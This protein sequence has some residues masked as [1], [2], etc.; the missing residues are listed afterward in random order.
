MMRSKGK[1]T[2]ALCSLIA[3]SNNDFEGTAN[4]FVPPT[5]TIA[6]VKLLLMPSFLNVKGSEFGDEGNGAVDAIDSRRM[7]LGRAAGGLTAAML[8]L[9]TTPS[10]AIA[11]PA[12]PKVSANGS[13]K[14]VVKQLKSHAQTECVSYRLPSYHCHCLIFLLV[15]KLHH[16]SLYL[17]NTDK[18]QLHWPIW[19]RWHL[20]PVKRIRNYLQESSLL[21]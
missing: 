18:G 10:S 3:L 21:I 20:F 11:A 12:P 19:T 1:I 2:F 16:I 7:V 8:T 5:T 13:K 15:I 4:A 6:N 9:L 17:K 14:Y